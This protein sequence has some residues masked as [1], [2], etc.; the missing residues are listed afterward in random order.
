MSLTADDQPLNPTGDPFVVVEFDI[1]QNFWYQP[2]EHVGI[3]LISMRSIANVTWRSNILEGERNNAWITYN[4]RSKNLS[5]VFTRFRSNSTVLQYLSY[6]VDLWLYLMALVT[7]S[8]TAATGNASAVH[9]IYS[10]DFSSSSIDNPFDTPTPCNNIFKPKKKIANKLVMGLGIDGFVSLVFIF[11]LVWL[12]ILWKRRNKENHLFE[13]YMYDEFQKDIGVPKKY[14]YRELA[15]A[16]NNFKGVAK[17]GEGGFGGVY[18]GC[19]RDI[20]SLICCC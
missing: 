12:G 6:E 2:K 8:F 18:K 11:C 14:R 7:F 5:V 1:Y 9:S 15:Q 3:D 4:S 16:T 17:L 19:L 10:W 13:N 20:D